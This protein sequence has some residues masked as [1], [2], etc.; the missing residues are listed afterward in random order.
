M[1][2]PNQRPRPTRVS[3]KVFS[4]NWERIFGKKNDN[5]TGER[6]EPG[7]VQIQSGADGVGHDGDEERVQVLPES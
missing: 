6:P 7:E 1:M 3:E 4:D 2:A 5:D